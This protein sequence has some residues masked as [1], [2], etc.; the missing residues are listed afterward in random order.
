MFRTIL[1]TAETNL[2][3]AGF[4]LYMVLKAW[5]NSKGCQ[6]KAARFSDTSLTKHPRSHLMG[7]LSELYRLCWYAKDTDGPLEQ[8]WGAIT[9]AWLLFY[10]SWLVSVLLPQDQFEGRT[11][12]FVLPSSHTPPQFSQK[13]RSGEWAVKV[14]HCVCLTWTLLYPV[15]GNVATEYDGKF[16][17]TVKL[18][19]PCS[20]LKTKASLLVIFHPNFGC[21]ICVFGENG[22]GIL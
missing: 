15:A 16:C 22:V 1:E 12:V 3:A 5:Y 2:S 9:A 19:D 4:T 17:N 6:K 18:Y 7:V 10:P 21:I 14:N 11:L 13:Y 20:C 8:V